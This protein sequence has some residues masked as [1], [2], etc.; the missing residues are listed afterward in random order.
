MS[1]DFYSNDDSAATAHSTARA[2]NV[3]AEF[4]AVEVGFDNVQTRINAVAGIIA[5]SA[6]SI[7]LASS[8]SLTF[9]LDDARSIPAG[10]YIVRRVADEDTFMVVNLATATSSSTTFTVTSRASAGTAGTYTDWLIIG[11]GG[12]RT[13]PVRDTTSDTTCV[14]ADLAE[15][16]TRT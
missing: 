9:T 15:T 10:G 8:G 16:S 11:L 13:T 5:T 14:A 3:T 12:V 1:N 4:D 7:T 2:A 6:T